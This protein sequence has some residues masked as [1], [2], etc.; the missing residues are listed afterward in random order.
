MKFKKS[1][2]YAGVLFEEDSSSEFF[3]QFKA[4][5]EVFIEEDS[6]FRFFSSPHLKFEEKKEILDQALKEAPALLKSFFKV[7]LKNKAFSFLPEIGKNYEKLWNEKNKQCEAL[8]F[9]S[10]ALTEEEKTNLKQQL[11]KFFNKKIA[12]KEK[13]D[14]SLIAGLKVNVEGYVFQAG[15]SHFL[16]KFEQS[17]GF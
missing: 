11:E 17:G 2:A 16:K 13:E 6:I 10:H 4:Y 7:L 14:K 5:I 8:V 9:R 3:K 15:T 1:E 12:L